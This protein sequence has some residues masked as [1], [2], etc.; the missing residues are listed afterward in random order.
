MTGIQETRPA[1]TTRW[2]VVTG[3][4]S[5]G[6]TTT[7]NLLRDRGYTTT[8]EHA[9]HYI[10]LQRI[11]GR[12]TEEIR[13]RQG[14]FQRAVV[15]MQITQERSLDPGETVFL[16]RALPDSLAYYRFLGID[17]APALLDA[18]AGARYA[19]VFLLDLLPLAPDYART[20]DPAAQRRIHDL[21]GQVY[22]ELG[23]PV[24]TVPALAPDARVDLILQRALAD[25]SAE[26]N[27]R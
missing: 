10:D 18:L 24:V 26:G 2:H 20:E 5:S 11:T 16:D 7:V 6:K 4:P 8:I 14:E 13:A 9:R 23:F 12:S 15:E 22:R 3:G 21:L 27:V 25:R 19:T 1:Q 17:P